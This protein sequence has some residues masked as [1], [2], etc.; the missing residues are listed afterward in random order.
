MK[1]YPFGISVVLIEPGAFKTKIFFDNK[2]FGGNFLNPHSPMYSFSKKINEKIG[3]LLQNIEKDPM[4]VVL[5]IQKVIKIKRPKLRYLIGFDAK[6]RL[7]LKT[8][9]PFSWYSKL[10][11][12][13]FKKFIQ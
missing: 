6:L 10:V 1:L 2:K 13:K 7:F 5:S 9:L 11:M 8:F 12:G 3:S 4:K